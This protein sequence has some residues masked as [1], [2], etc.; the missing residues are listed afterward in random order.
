MSSNRRLDI[1]TVQELIIAHGLTQQALADKLEVQADS[2][3]QWMTGRRSPSWQ[4]IVKLAQALGVE[5][6]HI[7]LYDPS[8]LYQRITDTLSDSLDWVQAVR[9]GVTEEELNNIQAAVKILSAV[10]GNIPLA[11]IK[12]PSQN[13]ND[14]DSEQDGDE[15][16]PTMSV[17]DAL[18]ML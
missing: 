3:S 10:C 11:D 15:C 14:E 7:L 18:E 16:E 8:K 5:T 12:L 6:S 9:D 2:V 1:T 17:E 13:A 4:N